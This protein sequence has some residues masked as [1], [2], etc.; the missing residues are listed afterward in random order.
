MVTSE[1]PSDG[2]SMATT[3]VK[4]AVTRPRSHSRTKVRSASG[5]QS[6]H[7][8]MTEPQS[9]SAETSPRPDPTDQL[10]ESSDSLESFKTASQSST[11]VLYQYSIKIYLE[12]CLAR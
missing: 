4:N 11:T 7:R 3:A 12:F 8:N 10:A 6:K 9:K 1:Q 5:D 2:V